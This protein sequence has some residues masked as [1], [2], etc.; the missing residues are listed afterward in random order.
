VT[1]KRN[2]SLKILSMKI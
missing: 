2:F 1:N